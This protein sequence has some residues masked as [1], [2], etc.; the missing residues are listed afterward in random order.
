ML[1]SGKITPVI[2]SGGAGSRLWP[3]SRK[4]EPKQFLPLVTE[5][6]M[7]QETVTRFESDLYNAPVFIC[8]VA[9]AEIITQQMAQMGRDIGAIIIEPEGRN[10]APCAVVAAVHA[11]QAETGQSDRGEAETGQLFLLV[12]A[13][14]HMSKPDEFSRVVAAGAPVAAKGHLVTFGM[15]PDHP[16]TGF[17]YIRKGQSLAA[18]I[19]D[20]EE[21]VEKPPAE[22]AQAYLDSGNYAW[23]SG[24]F[25]FNAET[26]LSEM[27]AYAPEVDKH[28]R[29]S[30]EQAV[31]K[32]GLIYLDGAEFSK[33][34][35]AP[36]DKAVM[37]HT[38]KAAVIPCDLGWHDIGS[39][40]ALHELKADENGM[41]VSGNVITE[42][43]TGALIDTDGPL[44]S[45]VGL[46]NVAVIVKVSTSYIKILSL[47]CE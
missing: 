33:I 28:S 19:F 34:P 4:A 26:L 13:D 21:F 38:K 30:Y 22:V 25:L 40:K 43:T 7:L 17:G 44:V 10:T 45:V 41:A 12:P 5:K 18:G 47:Q 46:E 16:A 23:N 8:N 36:V 2:M 24:I 20:V 39:F 15:M 1:E 35:S 27:Q 9:H 6:T 11:M 31:V 29:A 37:E 42:N 32:D 14:H 3:M